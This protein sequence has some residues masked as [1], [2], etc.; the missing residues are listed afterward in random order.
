MSSM[1]NFCY[2]KKKKKLNNFDIFD[3]FHKNNHT[4]KFVIR[5][6]FTFEEKTQILIENSKQ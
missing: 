1:S 2:I 3:I 5:Y 4:D 6:L